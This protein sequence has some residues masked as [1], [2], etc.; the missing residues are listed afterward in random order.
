R[1]TPPNGGPWAAPTPT[2][3]PA[4]PLSGDVVTLPR[5]WSGGRWLA[6]GTGGTIPWRPSHGAVAMRRGVCRFRAIRLE[7]DLAGNA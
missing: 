3:G 7:R 5:H 6:D 1:K 4:G 2:D